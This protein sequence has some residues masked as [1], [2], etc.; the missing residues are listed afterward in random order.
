MRRIAIVGA[1]P[2]GLE[3]ALE[4]RRRGHE[5]TVYERGRVGEHFR[6]YGDVVL[7]TPFRMNSTELGRARLAAAGAPVPTPEALLS[8]RDFALR[9]LVPLSRLPELKDSI[10]EGA[11][12]THVAREGLHK[13]DAIVAV[14]DHARSSRPFLLRVEARDGVRF[15]RA[16]AVLDASGVYATPNATGPGGLPAAGEERLGD[17]VERHLPSI[18]GEARVR[19]AGRRV[20][21][22]GDGASAATALVDLRELASDPGSAATVHWVRP[23][24]DGEP[25]DADPADPL[26]ARR[27][28]YRRANE[29]ARAEGWLTQHPGAEVLAYDRAE[30]GSLRVTLAGRGGPDRIVEVD[31]VLA[32]VGYRP[33]T[34]L[35][36][37]LH[38]HLCYASEGPMAL[39]SALLSASLEDPA[40]AGDCLA[41][42][43]HGAESLR[44]PEPDLFV[45][46]AKSYGRNRNFILSIGHE[47]LRDALDLVEAPAAAGSPA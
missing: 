21:L 36:R 32:L 46:G 8:A 31:R 18:P 10:H 2:V 3:A 30:V 41:Q 42:R 12:V 6:R 4:A 33:D 34:S 19:Y 38:M 39:A 9:Y 43:S 24:R 25:F 26:P 44:S 20:L 5:V 16:E 15:D 14:G 45:L 1:G 28:L 37:E 27:D 47:Q 13:P 17:L 11:R 35:T 40:R 29:A 23:R 7:F 22:V